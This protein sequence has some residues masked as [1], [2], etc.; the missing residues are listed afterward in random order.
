VYKNL[1]AEMARHGYKNFD[2][3]K[4][5]DICVQS[6]VNKKSGMR[7]FAFDECLKIRSNLFPE[8]T[9]EYLFEK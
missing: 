3:A 7:Q 4:A 9:L 1:R 5:A 2:L 8:L 6:V